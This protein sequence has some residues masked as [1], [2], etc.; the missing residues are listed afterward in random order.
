[1]RFFGAGSS[2]GGHI[3]AGNGL[4]CDVVHRFVV[5]F[6]LFVGVLLAFDAR[7]EAIFVDAVMQVPRAGPQEGDGG[8]KKPDFQVAGALKHG[9]YS[10][11]SD[12]TTPAW[13]KTP[14]RW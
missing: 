4:F 14:I 2:T 10:M 11:H 9:T 7:F 6:D 8:G 12:S 1:M 3:D 13:V 5:F